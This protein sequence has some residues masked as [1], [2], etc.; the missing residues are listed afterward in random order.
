MFINLLLKLTPTTLGDP[1]LYD[2]LKL[3]TVLKMIHDGS[4]SESSIDF[5]K[6]L[7][8]TSNSN[9]VMRIGYQKLS[10]KFIKVQTTGDMASI[11]TSIKHRKPTSSESMTVTSTTGPRSL[12]PTF[13]SNLHDDYR[14]KSTESFL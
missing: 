6:L 4:Y 11:V 8:K 5:S 10:S 3:D 13:Y 12:R 9:M 2:N 1:S 7:Q 14:H